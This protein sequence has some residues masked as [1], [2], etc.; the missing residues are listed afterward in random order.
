[1]ALDHVTLVRIQAGL[2]LGSGAAGMF[3]SRYGINYK[4][5]SKSFLQV[6]RTLLLLESNNMPE[7]RVDIN[8][9]WTT[10]MEVAGA[11]EIKENH[12]GNVLKRSNDWGLVKRWKGKSERGRLPYHYQVTKKGRR[13]L[14]RIEAELGREWWHLPE[15]RSEK[16]RGIFGPIDKHEPRR[17]T[18]VHELWSVSQSPKR[19]KELRA[20]YLRLR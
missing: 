19:S 11:L 14:E 7:V 17:G 9:T 20:E 16:E 6:L 13:R 2:P 1:M 15:T 3:N 12:A 5:E 8:R 4:P 10:V 18:L